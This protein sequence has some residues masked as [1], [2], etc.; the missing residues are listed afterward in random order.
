VLI[1]NPCDAPLYRRRRGLTPKNYIFEVQAYEEGYSDDYLYVYVWADDENEARRLA[2]PHIP[3]G[4]VVAY[5]DAEGGFRRKLLNAESKKQCEILKLSPDE[6]E[7]KR[8]MG[9]F[10]PK[11]TLPKPREGGGGFLGV[12]RFRN[13]F[14]RG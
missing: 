8:Q 9:F 10:F 6:K 12:S 1:I 11:S 14:R 13:P 3:D 4:K 2:R 5:V 7:K